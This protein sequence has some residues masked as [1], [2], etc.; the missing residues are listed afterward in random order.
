MVLLA[1]GAVIRY[2]HL[3]PFPYESGEAEQSGTQS[4][5]TQQPQLPVPEVHDGQNAAIEAEDVDD[6][7]ARPDADV[8]TVP[9]AAPVE[10]RIWTDRE[11]CRIGDE[12]EI[13]FSVQEPLHVRIA[14]INSRGESSELFPNDL[15]QDNYCLPGKV[16]R[17]PPADSGV[18]LFAQRPVRCRKA[19]KTTDGE[20][21]SV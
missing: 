9:A 19:G 18:P 12:M 4:V 21:N 2:W 16:Y 5:S 10:P 7:L 1:L 11:A 17:I 6:D 8:T 13:R 14:V 3:L 20:R 15:Q